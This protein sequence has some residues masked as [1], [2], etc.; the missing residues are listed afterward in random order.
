LLGDAVKKAGINQLIADAVKINDGTIP[1]P[2]LN[3]QYL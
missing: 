3:R 2:G 1:Y